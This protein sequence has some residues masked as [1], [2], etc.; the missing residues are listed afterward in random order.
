[1]RVCVLM[2]GYAVSFT[3]VKSARWYFVRYF[4]CC[5]IL[6]PPQFTTIALLHTV[7]GNPLQK[8]WSSFKC[9]LMCKNA[10]HAYIF[11]S[12]F[13]G[14]WNKQEMALLI[15]L[16]LIIKSRKENMSVIH[17]S[18]YSCDAQARH[19]GHNPSIQNDTDCW[20]VAMPLCHYEPI[21]Y[22]DSKIN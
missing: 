2:Y 1:M 13:Q 18:Q 22:T 16:F 8:L 9:T 10:M 21:Y 7:I 4:I 20:V 15:W 12:L 5:S 17:I 6:T 11:P 14:T 3:S 19:F